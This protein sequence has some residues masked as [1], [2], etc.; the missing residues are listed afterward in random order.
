[1]LS[2]YGYGY[3]PVGQITTWT[4]TLGSSPTVT[5]QIAY[6][7]ADQV[8]AVGTGNGTSPI[9][10]Y[11]YQY[12][13]AGNRT[14][15]QVDPTLTNSSFNSLNQL[16][17]QAGG[18]MLTVAGTVSAP[19]TVS[20]NGTAVSSDAS[21]TWV[22]QSTVT[23]GSNSLPIVATDLNGNTTS[24][25]LSTSVTSGSSRT[26]S[27]DLNG[28]LTN[29]GAGK[30]YS[31]NAR[32][33]LVS[34]TQ[35]SGST[36]FAYDG[37]GRLVQESLNGT[38]IKQWVWAGA[39]PQPSEERDGTNAVTKRFYGQ[40]EQV[41]GVAYFYTL[42]HLGS[43]REL[44][45]GT[46]AV[47]AR[48]DYDPYGRI[49]KV[50]GD[51]EADFGFTGFYRHQISGLYLTHYRAFDPSLGRWLA[52]DPIAE[53]GGINLY[54][55]VGNNPVNSIDTQGLWQVTL[56]AGD[57]AGFTITFGHNSGQWNIGGTVGV[58]V[59]GFLNVNPRDTGQHCPGDNWGVY[60]RSGGTV[61]GTGGFLGV[62]G[63]AYAPFGSGNGDPT[64]QVGLTFRGSPGGANASVNLGGFKFGPGQNGP[65]AT[66]AQGGSFTLGGGGVVGVGDVHYF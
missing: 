10:G 39:D 46:G 4:K 13:K 20:I 18:S 5:E 50:S 65:S 17:S 54:A 7:A 51:L 12:D 6:D 3:S 63:N 35:S 19:S 59:G 15:E 62:G 8:I 53:Q 43:I 38:L 41:G 55:Y 25:T 26:L 23:A 32:N 52:R 31:W 56:G 21:G 45:D 61:P 1:M 34:I 42:D 66:F 40:G 60:G 14:V 9:Q 2:S 36:G 33:Q 30:T 29:D 47:R 49:T 44:T 28:N 22:G 48:Y 16:L 27:Y 58:G 57:G 37:L 64:A 11:A 24:K